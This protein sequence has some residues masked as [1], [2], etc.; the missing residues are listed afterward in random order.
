MSDEP[1]ELKAD[2][3]L[4]IM[5][6]HDQYFELMNERLPELDE[7]ILEIYLAALG[8]LVDKLEDR[9]KTLREVAQEM[10]GE[11]AGVVMKHLT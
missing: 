9:D 2:V 8:K 5:D 11:V 7:E 10:F 3:L 6:T 4:Q 1:A